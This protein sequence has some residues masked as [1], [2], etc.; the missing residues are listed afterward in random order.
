MGDDQ[1]PKEDECRCRLELQGEDNNAQGQL[2]YHFQNEAQFSLF[3]NP[4][5]P[6]TYR[7]DDQK[8][9]RSFP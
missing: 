2:G 6:K 7:I 5:I 1:G 8:N 3:L 4:T 9:G